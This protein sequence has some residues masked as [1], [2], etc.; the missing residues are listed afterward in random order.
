MDK[1]EFMALSL[2]YGLKVLRGDNITILK[3]SGID[4]DCKSLLFTENHTTTYGS[5]S[6]S[7]PILRPLSEL[8]KEI[9]HKCDKFIPIVELAKISGIKY[10]VVRK[11]GQ[12]SIDL[13]K[14]NDD[15]SIRFWYE[16]FTYNS[17]LACRNGHYFP[18]NQLLLIQKLI[19]WHFDIAGLI[20][21]NEAIDYHALEG[22]SF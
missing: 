4:V 21:K 15:F 19:E 12:H 14:N 2:P 1:K 13:G 10:N 16:S 22:F 20:D 5:V 11:I 7:K 17:F 6:H 3:V 9:E 8:T 18:I